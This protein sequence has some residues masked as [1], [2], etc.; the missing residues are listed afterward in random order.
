MA[1][2]IAGGETVLTSGAAFTLTDGQDVQGIHP[3]CIS[4][5]YDAFTGKDV[6]DTIVQ[7][8]SRA[9]ATPMEVF[10]AEATPD[11]V[12][13]V[14]V[15]TK[16]ELQDALEFLTAAVEAAGQGGET[17]ATEATSM[18][19]DG[20]DHTASTSRPGG[21]HWVS[22]GGS[23]GQEAMQ[24]DAGAPLEVMLAPDEINE[25]LNA[26]HRRNVSLIEIDT[27]NEAEGVEPDIEADPLLEEA[28]RISVAS[29]A[30][31]FHECLP[32]TEE[33]AA[34]LGFVSAFAPQNGPV[35]RGLQDDAEIEEDLDPAVLE[36]LD[37]AV[38]ALALVPDGAA[39]KEVLSLHAISR[40]SPPAIRGGTSFSALMR[41]PRQGCTLCVTR[42]PSAG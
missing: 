42:L 25:A 32:A 9:Q 4:A 34:R 5:V 10:T 7:G 27:D 31:E 39:A 30:P 37:E 20:A 16:E 22:R 36:S 29:S 33:D 24:V 2:Y 12:P 28:D 18:S 1:L 3:S 13:R 11:D 40:C 15:H 26:L 17:S 23:V 38:A 6:T 35:G 8:S 21:T 14:T 19:D 41:P